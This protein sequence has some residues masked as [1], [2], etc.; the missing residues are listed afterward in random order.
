MCGCCLGN[1]G[2]HLSTLLW[3]GLGLRT[4]GFGNHFNRRVQGLSS[5]DSLET[6]WE[7]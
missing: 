2:R 4:D 1:V 5:N 6:L 7:R 3:S